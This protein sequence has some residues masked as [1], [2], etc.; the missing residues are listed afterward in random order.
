MAGDP[1]LD[2]G[3]NTGN[4]ILL[5]GLVRVAHGGKVVLILNPCGRR[6][7]LRLRHGRDGKKG[8]GHAQK[9]EGDT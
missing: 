5:S 6:F 2:F 4:R 1:A 7:P 8:D 9:K 3:A